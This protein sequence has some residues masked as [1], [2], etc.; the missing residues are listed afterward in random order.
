MPEHS[1]QMNVTLDFEREVEF[2]FA[3]P[4]AEK[5]VRK[6]AGLFPLP[7]LFEDGYRA[8]SRSYQE[9]LDYDEDTKV[10][11][12]TLLGT[13]EIS[14]AHVEHGDTF[15]D[16]KEIVEE[17]VAELGSEFYESLLPIDLKG[18]SFDEGSL[19]VVRPSSAEHEDTQ[20]PRP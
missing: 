11:S 20:S 6:A 14:G 8:V 3:N 5:A 18:W 12:G 7:T 10:W 19:D 9:S 16:A 15:A 4:D 17:E 13:V 1:L 2:K